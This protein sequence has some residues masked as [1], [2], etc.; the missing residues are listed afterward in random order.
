[1]CSVVVLWPLSAK[2]EILYFDGLFLGC[3]LTVGIGVVL[4]G[5][6]PVDLPDHENFFLISFYFTGQSYN[7]STIVNYDSR[8]TTTANF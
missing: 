8:V 4:E 6:G 1:M 7:H 3:L 2:S 5:G